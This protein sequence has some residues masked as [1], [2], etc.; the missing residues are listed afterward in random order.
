MGCYNISTPNVLRKQMLESYQSAK[1]ADEHMMKTDHTYNT[2]VAAVK[3]DKAVLRYVCDRQ[4]MSI[5]DRLN[6]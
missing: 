6:K 1:S 3:S 4:V 5:G 2:Y